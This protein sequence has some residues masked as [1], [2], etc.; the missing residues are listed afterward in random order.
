MDKTISFLD[1]ES[2]PIT[3]GATQG[4]NVIIEGVEP[5]T[6]WTIEVIGT[7]GERTRIDFLGERPKR[8]ER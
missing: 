7:N 3:E 1:P 6:E 4:C 2:N 8:E 5:S